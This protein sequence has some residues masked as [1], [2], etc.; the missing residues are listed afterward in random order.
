M[1]AVAILLPCIVTVPI[2]IGTG[3]SAFP[4]FPPFLCV[5]KNVDVL[6]YTF[7]PPASLI[8]GIGI[9]LLV[10]IFLILIRRTKTP[11]RKD[12]KQTVSPSI[13]QFTKQIIGWYFIIYIDFHR[14]G[15]LRQN[16]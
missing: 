16:I 7:V 3:G 8:L 5:S 4:F 2:V 14:A 10:P 15:I 1:V 12:A 9:S 6:F 13:L 11:Q